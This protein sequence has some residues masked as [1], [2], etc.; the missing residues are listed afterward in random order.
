[1]FE[2]QIL[3]NF[4]FLRV[5]LFLIYHSYTRSYREVVYLTATKRSFIPR[6]PL[7]SN[8]LEFYDVSFRFHAVL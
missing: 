2:V 4:T 6:G 3:S 1:M 5:L 8:L 7:S